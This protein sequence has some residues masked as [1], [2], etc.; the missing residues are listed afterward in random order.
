MKD[1]KNYILESQKGDLHQ[2]NN[3]VKLRKG[4]TDE[5]R[6]FYRSL[7][8]EYGCMNDIENALRKLTDDELDQKFK[9]VED[10]LDRILGYS[11]VDVTNRYALTR[12]GKENKVQTI[13]Q[14][15][16]FAGA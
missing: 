10:T 1:L 13:A 16:F 4:L 9:M 11:T 8:K 2:H 3:R 12:T 14:V 15:S 7:R 6:N 5:E